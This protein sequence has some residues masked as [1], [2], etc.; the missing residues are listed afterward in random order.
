M[1]APT[2]LVAL[3]ADAIEFVAELLALGV[4]AI[5]GPILFVD[6]GKNSGGQHG[7]RKACAFLIGPIDHDDGMFG[8]DVEIIQCTDQFEPAED[9]K[10]AVKFAA[11]RLGIEMAA[12]IDRQCVGIGP[13]TRKEHIAHG[14]D[15]HGKA[16]LLAPGLEQPAAFAVFVG[17][18]LAVVAATNARSDLRHLHQTVPETVAVDPE[19]SRERHGAAPYARFFRTSASVSKRCS[20]WPLLMMSGGDSAMISP[21]VRMSTPFS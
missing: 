17:Q 20:I 4:L 5:V 21:V 8:L 14:V 13:R 2:L 7:R 19:I 15:A 11:R 3:P 16:C 1:R 6:A 18:C 10:H 12:D 9:A